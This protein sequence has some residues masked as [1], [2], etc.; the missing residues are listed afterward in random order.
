MAWYNFRKPKKKALTYLDPEQQRLINY[1]NQAF[2]WGSFSTDVIDDDL[3]QKLYIDAA[4]N[5][6]PDVYSVINQISNKFTSIPYVIREIDDE[7]EYK[8]LQVL[9]KATKYDYSIK[10]ELKAIS[11]KD[12][13]YNKDYLPMPLER[14]NPSQTWKEFWRLSVT[15][16]NTNGN[17][18]WYML[19]PEGGINAGEPIAI[20]VL[21][22]HLMQIVLKNKVDMLGVE[23][24][25][26]HYMLTEGRQYIEF[27]VEDV[28]HIKYPNPNYDQNGAH[29]Y[30]QSPLRAAYK[31]IVATNKGLDLSVNTMKNGGAFG[32]IH[33]KGETTALDDA[34]AKAIKDRLK[35]MNASS[36][37]LS[38]IAGM[39]MELGFT[40]IGLNADELK[41]FEY[42]KYNMKQICNVLGWDDKLLNSDDGA[43]YDNMKIAEKRSVTGKIV[44][45]IELI[46]Q[47]FSKQFLSLYKKYENACIVFMV[48]ELPEMQQDYKTMI[49]WIEKAVNIGL[50]TRN[51]SLKIMGLPISEEPEADLLTVKDDIMTLADAVLPQDG[52]QI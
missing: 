18:Y 41:P 10:Q 3:N 45:D 28:I 16:L 49:E 51:Q 7:S 32:F 22:S 30:G 25:I 23:S 15:F 1:F 24:P 6:N 27:D 9:N 37:D 42:F 13:S 20:Y 4:Y 40:Q 11:L 36:E 35:E 34:Q 12:K 21:P 52:I 50:I 29:L 43:K 8:R 33:P 31:N 44:P 19:R 17:I 26:D 38:R 48:K 39:S 2:L 5:I 47:A 46:S 14:P